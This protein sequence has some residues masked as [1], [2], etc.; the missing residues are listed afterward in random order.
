VD[1]VEAGHCCGW[2]EAPPHRSCGV[3]PACVVEPPSV[4]A[5]PSVFVV[6]FVEVSRRLTS[7]RVAALPAA[8][9]NA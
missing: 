5:P 8:G 2:G 6:R 3:S 9:S 1:C 4:V 7:R